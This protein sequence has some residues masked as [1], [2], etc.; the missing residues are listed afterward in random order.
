MRT[1]LPLFPLDVV[2]FPG[3]PL[4]LHIFEPRYRALIARC[5]ESDQT[6]GVALMVSDENGETAPAQIGCATE[7]IESRR[8]P[9]GRINVQTVGRRRFEI[10]SLR[11][12]DDYLVGEVEWLEDEETEEEAAVL[13]SQ[14]LRSLRRYLGAIGAGIDTSVQQEWN[15]PTEP[16]G[17]SMWIAAL[18]AAPNS[19][20][21][22]LLETVSTRE[23]LELELAILRRAEIVQQAFIKRQSWPKPDFFDDATK[24]FEPF[25][26]LN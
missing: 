21:Q 15:V 11:E 23:R 20:K 5:L 17:V 18:L 4:P 13:S 24:N 1:E 16:L 26:S 19:I 3:M 12:E 6:F 9:D 2:L 25:M 7:I 14:A 8:L 22:E 10:L